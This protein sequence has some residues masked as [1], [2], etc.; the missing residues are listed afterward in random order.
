MN[1]YDFLSVN[2]KMILYGLNHSFILKYLNTVQN[3]IN[4]NIYNLTIDLPEEIKK[5]QNLLNSF[6]FFNNKRKMF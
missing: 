3:K 2:H 4:S 6:Q 5:N 1:I